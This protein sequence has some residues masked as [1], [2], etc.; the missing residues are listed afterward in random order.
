MPN[1]RLHRVLSNVAAAYTN[2]GVTTACSLIAVPAFV[3]FLT[4]EEYGLWLTILSFLSPL[5]IVGLGFPTV[6]QNMLAEARAHGDWDQVNRVV[7]TG[8]ALLSVCTSLNCLLVLLLARTGIFERLLKTTPGLR[9]QALMVVLISLTGYALTQPLQ[10][11]RLAL[12]ALERVD[13]EQ[14]SMS[15]VAILNLIV[16]VVVLVIGGRLVTVATAYLAVQVLSGGL[17]LVYLVRKFPRL[18]LS[19]AHVSRTMAV[20]MLAPGFHFLVLSLSGVLIWGVDNIVIS[21]VLG[22]A[23]VTAFALASRLTSILRGV[24]I[25]LFGTIVPTITSL[26]AEK[27][28]ETLRRVQLVSTKLAM[29][30]AL[31]LGIELGF[32]GRNFISLWAGKQVLVDAKTFWCLAGVL[33]VNVFLQ[34]PF[35]LIV[36]TSEHRTYSYLCLGEGAC[37][38]ILSYWWVHLWGIRGVALGT[39]VSHILFSGLYLPWAEMQIIGLRMVRIHAR[40]LFRLAAPATAAVAVALGT[41]GNATNWGLW[42]LYSSAT[43]A[44]FLLTYRAVA[45]DPE[46]RDVLRDTFSGRRLNFG[47]SRG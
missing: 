28:V 11:F 20:S 14:K 32:F 25:T 42:V 5:T 33:V 40:F 39:L 10:V 16:L 45:L 44:A 8:F 4:A 22:V 13:L 43:L 3:R 9:S 15:V 26:H 36:A 1:I 18:R 30:V 27:R 35:S 37:N 34:P 6:I 41:G 47:L 7:A 12:R 21:S 24:V 17:F 46:E 23:F 19:F 38:L 2:M 31:L 29:A